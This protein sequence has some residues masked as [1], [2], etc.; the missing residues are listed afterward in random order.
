MPL[1]TN[2]AKIELFTSTT[3]RLFIGVDAESDSYRKT[4]TFYQELESDDNSEQLKNALNLIKNYHGVCGIP[5]VFMFYDE[6][7]RDLISL[8]KFAHDDDGHVTLF[9]N[10]YGNYVNGG[11]LHVKY[12]YP[13]PSA[14][15]CKPK[16]T[17]RFE[18]K[19]EKV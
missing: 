4:I 9:E 6:V 19:K 16:L 11:V 10:K 13:T 18:I 17:L 12:E 1:S 3:N 15:Y 2:T 14:Q 8:M 5:H 7:Y